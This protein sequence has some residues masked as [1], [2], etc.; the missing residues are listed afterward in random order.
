MNIQ[1]AG[2]D[3]NVTP[4]PCGSGPLDLDALAAVEPDVLQADLLSEQFGLETLPFDLIDRAEREARIHIAELDQ[5][6][7]PSFHAQLRAMSER[8]FAAAITACRQARLADDRA[9]RLRDNAATAAA[10]NSPNRYSLDCI[11]TQAETHAAIATLH[12]LAESHRARGVDAAV[13]L[14]LIGV[15]HSFIFGLVEIV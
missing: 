6:D 5:T 14:K 1:A 15:D 10:K 8:A 3:Y 9:A 4:F 12:A 7:Q 2:S 11:A 13:S